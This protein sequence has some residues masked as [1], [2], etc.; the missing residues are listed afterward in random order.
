MRQACGFT[1]FLPKFC[2]PPF[3]FISLNPE[4]VSNWVLMEPVALA[5]EDM[6]RFE[7]KCDAIGENIFACGARTTEQH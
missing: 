2:G 6:G 1:T 7:V 4:D 5:Y 3:H